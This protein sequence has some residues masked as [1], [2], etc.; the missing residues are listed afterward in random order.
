MLRI[1]WLLL[2]THPIR[3]ARARVGNRHIPAS[4]VRVVW[5]RDGGRCAY[6]DDRGERCRETAGL[7]IHHRKAFALGGTR[8]VDDPGKSPEGE[9]LELRCRA[10]NT[11]AAEED[12]GR[13]HMDWMRGVTDEAAPER[14]SLL[15]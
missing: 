11:L 6:C 2:S 1:E 4:V 3:T 10:H 14:A 8:T 12:F 5:A 9:N 15:E 7:E 13:R